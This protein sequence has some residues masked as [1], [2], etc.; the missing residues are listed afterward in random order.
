MRHLHRHR[1]LLSIHDVSPKFESEI[2][3]LVDLYDEL[4]GPSRFAML[5]VPNHWGDAPLRDAPAFL[6]K[7]R[8]WADQGVEMFMHGVDHKAPA[9]EAPKGFKAKHMTAGEGEFASLKALDALYRIKEAR[10]ELQD[11]LGKRLAGFIAPAW[12]YSDGT[13]GAI[14]SLDFPIAENH[15]RVWAPRR[16]ETLARGPVI[17][18]ASRSEG[19]TRSSLAFARVAQTVLQP[20]KV[21]RIAVHPGDTGKPEILTSVRA[22]VEALRRNR[23][24]DRYASLIPPK[25]P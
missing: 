17:T 3:Q 20:M 12:L 8:R 11:M 6:A 9:G 19:R 16:N 2:D 23:T 25:L 4:V 21:V 14:A 24:V 10:D 18:W 5:V 15:M 13:Y 7:L 22:T 1:L